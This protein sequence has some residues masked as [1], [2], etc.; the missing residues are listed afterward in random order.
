MAGA[1]CWLCCGRALVPV[2]PPVASR[3]VG[4]RS[5]SHR[6]LGGGGLSRHI[7]V[8]WRRES[9]VLDGACR[10]GSAVALSLRDDLVALALVPPR[11]AYGSARLVF[12]YARLVFSY[13]VAW[14]E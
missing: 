6:G 12:S 13:A 10:V 5:G 1:D 2:T 7:V 14:L 8:L 11:V 3:S 4:H 9:A